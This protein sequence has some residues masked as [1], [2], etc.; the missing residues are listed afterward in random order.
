VP[1][2]ELLIV[3]D[4]ETDRLNSLMGWVVETAQLNSATVQRHLCACSL[5]T[6]G[7]KPVTDTQ[8]RANR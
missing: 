2:G 8:I 4:E 7:Q 5:L 6:I 1:R 3:I